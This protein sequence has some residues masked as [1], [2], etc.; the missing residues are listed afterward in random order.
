MRITLNHA[1]GARTTT[2]RMLQDPVDDGFPDVLTVDAVNNVAS[3]ISVFQEIFKFAHENHIT[4]VNL[5]NM[6]RNQVQILE[7]I[8]EHATLFFSHINVVIKFRA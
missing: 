2:L 6:K 5:I 8:N 4:G 1:Q 7:L 3:S